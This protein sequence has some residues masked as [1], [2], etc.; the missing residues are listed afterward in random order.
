MEDIP[1]GLLVA[2][3]GFALGIIFGATAQSTNFCTMGA[4]SD[5]IFIGNWNR[6][7]AWILSISIA[8]LLSQLMHFNSVIN[9][10]NSIYLSPNFSWLGAI[11]GGLMF[12]FGMTLAGGCGNRI[13]VR[14]G[15]GNLKSLITF[16]FLG[17]FTLK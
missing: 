9:L 13:L 15:A 7:R 1:I 8:V 3:I 5:I 6:F 12:G 10:N 11:I 16:I 2:S 4:I 17:L 14:I